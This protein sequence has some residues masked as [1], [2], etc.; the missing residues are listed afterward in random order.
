[1][2]QSLIG[3]AQ[4]VF[5]LFQGPLG[6]AL[7]GIMLGIAFLK[8]AGGAHHGV[9]YPAVIGVAGAATVGWLVNYLWAGGAG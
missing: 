9:L 7:G 1:M 5:A 4:S 6:L 2:G 8:M 3:L